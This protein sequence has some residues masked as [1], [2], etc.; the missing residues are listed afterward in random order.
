MTKSEDLQKEA[1]D[2][3]AEAAPAMVNLLN[4]LSPE[5]QRDI[6]EEAKT[7]MYSL[8]PSNVQ[9]TLDDEALGQG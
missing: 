1:W 6:L 4:T 5:E 8:L 7:K 9:E 2:S 3:I